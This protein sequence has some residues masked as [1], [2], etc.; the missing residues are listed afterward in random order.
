MMFIVNSRSGTGQ[1]RP[2][3][4][5]ILDTF[6]KA[7]F[8]PT[9]Y[10]TQAAGAARLKACEAARAGIYDRIVCS[11]GDGTLNE[12]ISGVLDSGTDITIGYLPA[13]STND[14]S[15]S[16]EIPPDLQQAALLAARGTPHRFDVGTMNDRNFIYVA[17][18]G[19]FTALTYQTPQQTKNT[20]G[21]MAYVLEA[22]QSLGS[23]RPYHIRVEADG[24]S[25][26]GDYILGLVTNSISVG[27]I[28]LPDI[29][30]S[31]LDDGLLEVLLI[32]N[33]MNVFELQVILSD[34]LTANSAKS[35]YVDFFRAK[36][37]VISS[38]EEIA[39]TVDG[40][41]GGACREAVITN[42]P[43]AVRIMTRRSI[44]TLEKKPGRKAPGGKTP[45]GKAP[46]DKTPD[47]KGIE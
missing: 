22:V 1:I 7:G 9:V 6:N 21:Y 42:R 19:A 24:R 41:A 14:F 43:Q 2:R 30:G 20:L 33:P 5:D 44:G 46:E 17:A 27:G 38:E 40:E 32:R 37:V 8:E 47:G 26:E 35:Q 39:W 10:I 28:P 45:D 3:L 18:F 16:L 15:R 23:I 4:C 11:G 36:R 12:V 25:F 31:S 13:G 34:L 29:Q